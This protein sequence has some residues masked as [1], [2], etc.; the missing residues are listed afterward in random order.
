MLLVYPDKLSELAVHIQV[1]K[2]LSLFDWSVIFVAVFVQIDFI[3]EAFASTGV[4]LTL[5]LY[6]TVAPSH[7]PLCGVIV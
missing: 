1:K 4:G 5:T 7:P 2:V 6:N 3:F